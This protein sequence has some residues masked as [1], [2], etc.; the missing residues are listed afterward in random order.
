LR[1]ASGRP[2]LAARALTNLWN[3]GRLQEHANGRRAHSRGLQDRI[4]RARH[5]PRGHGR[6]CCQCKCRAR[7]PKP[8][9]LR[10]FGG[11]ASLACAA[12]PPR[13]DPPPTPP[14]RPA[15][16]SDCC[17][18]FARRPASYRRTADA[19]GNARSA[20][21][22][23]VTRSARASN[24]CSSRTRR[25]FPA[26]RPPHPPPPAPPHRLEWLLRRLRQASR[27]PLPHGGRR[28]HS[29]PNADT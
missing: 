24:V 11:G 15:A 6:L 7:P 16:P 5:P 8:A 1:R 28:A 10:A 25:A 14:R 26:R 18:A 2:F 23:N 27:R 21:A 4:P 17:R 19:A 20:R 29:Q 9:P 22:G 3:F 12:P 13:A